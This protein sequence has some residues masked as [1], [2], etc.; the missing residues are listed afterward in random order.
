MSKRRCIIQNG[1][2]Y[3]EGS[4]DES[5]IYPAPCPVEVFTLAEDPQE[6]Q[7]RLDGDSEMARK[8]GDLMEGMAR[9]L[10]W[11]RK[12]RKDKRSISSLPPELEKMLKQQGYL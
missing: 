4:T 10:D 8:L 1:W 5:L 12:S 3:I 11:L 2:K 7:N 6:R 9:K